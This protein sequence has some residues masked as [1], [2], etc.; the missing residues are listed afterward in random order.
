MKNY[1]EQAANLFASKKQF[2][3]RY[4]KAELL[5]TE[6]KKSLAK[7][8]LYPLHGDDWEKVF[9][10][11]L[12]RAADIS[13]LELQIAQMDSREIAEWIYELQEER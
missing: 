13:S 10:V 6:A 8:R 12:K 1:K 2:A 5:R 7:K 3:S 9:Q 11:E 4:Q